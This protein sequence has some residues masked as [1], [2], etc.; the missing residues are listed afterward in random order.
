MNT[1][2]NSPGNANGANSKSDVIKILRSGI[3]NSGNATGVTGIIPVG[4][5]GK[6]NII[7]GNIKKWLKQ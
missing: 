3:T 2:W 5:D 6:E 7:D 4:I 1:L